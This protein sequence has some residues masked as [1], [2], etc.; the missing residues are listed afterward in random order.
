MHEGLSQALPAVATLAVRAGAEILDVYGSDFGVEKKGDNSPLTEADT[1]SND[2][3]VS[4]LKELKV[5]SDN[6]IPI[7]SEESKQVEFAD[8]ED[9]D[10]LWLVDPL[11]GTKDFVNKNGEFTVNIG[12]VHRGNP[13]AG[14]MYVPVQGLLYFGSN[15]LGCF[16]LEI[17]A[18]ESDRISELGFFQLCEMAERLTGRP[19]DE[20][21]YTIIGSRS[22]VSSEFEDY[23]K[24]LEE[25]YPDLE[26]I[27]AGSALKFCR[28]AE[29][30][31]DLYPRLGPTME[32]DT[33]AGHALVRAVGKTVRVFSSDEELS[34]NKKELRNP[35]FI[36][37]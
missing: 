21:P 13:L 24:H 26:M 12:L 27:S 2:V 8:R 32:W 17:G 11:D 4:G 33:A 37:K 15:E 3:I 9:W 29:G 19:T 31:A 34:Y 23:L 20:R 25:E 22:H 7:L 14:V 36:V 28:I 35:W 6:T 5:F 30:K 1:R 10:Y 16:R 18:D